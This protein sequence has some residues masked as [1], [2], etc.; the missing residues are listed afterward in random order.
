M[1]ASTDGRLAITVA[2]AEMP[3]SNDI[4]PTQAPGSV[5]VATTVPSFSIRNA[6]SINTNS[7]S[8]GRPID[9]QHVAGRDR[10]PGEGLCQR[11]E[12]VHTRSIAPTTSM[13]GV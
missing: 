5:T 1:T 10:T 3:S 7:E 4:S 12:L 9:E 2:V 6:P 11:E 13:T 8:T